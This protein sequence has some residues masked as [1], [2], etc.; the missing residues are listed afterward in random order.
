MRAVKK[1]MHNALAPQINMT[2]INKKQYR[3]A[4]LSV[5]E[6]CRYDK[7]ESLRI[8]EMLGLKEELV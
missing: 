4:A 5:I 3:D 6:F 2:K 8:I 1:E 7:S